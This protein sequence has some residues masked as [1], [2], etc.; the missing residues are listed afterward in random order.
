MPYWASLLLTIQKFSLTAQHMRVDLKP[1]QKPVVQ[2]LPSP[3]RNVTG[4]RSL[5]ASSV[6]LIIEGCITSHIKQQRW[7]AGYYRYLQLIGTRPLHC[8]T[9]TSI[10]DMCW[11]NKRIGAFIWEYW[12]VP[13][14]SLD[15]GKKM[16]Q[17]RF[18]LTVVVFQSWGCGYL[19]TLNL[20]CWESFTFSLFTVLLG[21]SRM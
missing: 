2:A 19:V 9:I 15:S 7:R 16:K 6:W 8:C 11:L 4:I 13:I 10:R 20:K 3:K 21:S 1:F 18:Y 17:A 12:Y 14:N 5:W